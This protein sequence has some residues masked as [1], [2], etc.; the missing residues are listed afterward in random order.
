MSKDAGDEKTDGEKTDGEK[1]DGDGGQGRCFRDRQ[2]PR[3]SLQQ[4]MALAAK[5]AASGRFLT[6][7][8]R[9]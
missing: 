1:T 2:P 9:V 3:F 5:R 6:V 8:R 4:Q 7:C